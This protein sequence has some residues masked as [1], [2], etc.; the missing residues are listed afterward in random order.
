[1][2][3]HDFIHKIFILSFLSIVRS[4]INGTIMNTC[5]QTYIL[6]L[7]ET[8]IVKHVYKKDMLSTLSCTFA[9]IFDILKK[10]AFHIYQIIASGIRGHT[11]SKQKTAFEQKDLSL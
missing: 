11:L 3:T 7:I 10:F 6:V 2:N 4:Y 8:Y 9:F 1:M 5:M